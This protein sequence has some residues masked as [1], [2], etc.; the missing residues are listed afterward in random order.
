M[1]NA[2]EKLT[3]KYGSVARESVPTE[4]ALGDDRSLMCLAFRLFILSAAKSNPRE[5]RRTLNQG[6]LVPE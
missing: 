3:I 4:G 1:R 5:T 2:T 6:H